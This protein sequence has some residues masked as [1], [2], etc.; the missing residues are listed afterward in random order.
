MARILLDQC[1]KVLLRFVGT[2]EAVE[3]GGHLNGGIAV[4]R[5]VR[6]NAFVNLDRKL[7]LLQRLIK[8]GERK[9]RQRMCR[10]EKQREL[11][12]DQTEILAATATERGAESVERFSAT[13]LRVRNKRWQFLAS[14]ELVHCFDHERM[15]RQRLVESLEDRQRFLR[16]AIT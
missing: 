7:G 16:R 15:T 1:L 8:I 5:R 14:L 13:G 12:I 10:G 2:V 9:K 4:Q 3:V 11:E 6:R